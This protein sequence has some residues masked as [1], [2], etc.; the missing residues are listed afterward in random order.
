MEAVAETTIVSRILLQFLNEYFIW[1]KL[2]TFHLGKHATIQQPINFNGAS[3][4]CL[5]SF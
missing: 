3:F 1:A 5:L 4:D 2:V